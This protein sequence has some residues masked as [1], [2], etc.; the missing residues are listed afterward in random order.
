MA[1]AFKPHHNRHHLV[2][3]TGQLLSTPHNYSDS[4]A[5]LEVNINAIQRSLNW[6]VIHHHPSHPESHR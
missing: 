6:M 4:I 1:I 5:S 2:N 3:K